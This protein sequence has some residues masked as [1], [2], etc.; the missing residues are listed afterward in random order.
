[1]D[2]CFR[3]NPNLLKYDINKA[4]ENFSSVVERYPH[5][6]FAN[7]YLGEAYLKKGEKSKAIQA[8]QDTL[9]SNPE[10]AAAKKR[11]E[12]LQATNQN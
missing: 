11:I 9:K 8:Y 12:E 3:N 6:D 1:M 10:H 7:F 4:I 5:F 2:V